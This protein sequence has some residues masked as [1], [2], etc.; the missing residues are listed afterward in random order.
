MSDLDWMTH[1]YFTIFLKNDCTN[2]LEILNN[3]GE[4][5]KEIL[6]I[7]FLYLNLVNIKN[8]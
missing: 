6:E 3:G 7:C 5:L 2:F 8:L 1:L 4:V